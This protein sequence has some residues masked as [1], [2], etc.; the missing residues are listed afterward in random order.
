MSSTQ[1]CPFVS[2]IRISTDN[3][4]GNVN[5]DDGLFR[6][7]LKCCNLLDK[8]GYWLS[9]NTGVILE[10]GHVSVSGF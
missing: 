10:K 9:G 6:E 7:W 8:H 3:M 4:A 2:L 5:A 1:K